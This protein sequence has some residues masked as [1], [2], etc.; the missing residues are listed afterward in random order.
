MESYFAREFR[1][2]RD[3]FKKCLKKRPE[4]FCCK[5]YL[6]ICEELILEPPP[7]DWDGREIM[8]TK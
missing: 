6:D 5:K 4:D 7:A 2:A 3:G 1:V 8:K